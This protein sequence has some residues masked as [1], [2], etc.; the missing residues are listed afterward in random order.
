[1]TFCHI[2][3]ISYFFCQIP[4]IRIYLIYYDP[5][6]I[7]F[8]S[9]MEK[10]MKKKTKKIVALL[11]T[12]TLLLGNTL[13]VNA[14]GFEWPC[15]HPIKYLKSTSYSYIEAGP[16][17]HKRQEDRYTQCLSCPMY[18]HEV[19]YKV[20]SHTPLSDGKCICGYRLY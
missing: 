15:T 4:K 6:T 2:I 1:M 13:S 9:G 11:F 7:H 8:N 19:I 5:V 20:E 18:F 14:Q 16:Q 3:Q 17:T 12:I 10:T